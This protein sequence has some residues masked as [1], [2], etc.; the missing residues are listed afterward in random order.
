MLRKFYNGCWYLAGTCILLAAVSVSIARLLLPGIDE[1][2]L[3][4]QQLINQHSGYPVTIESVRAEWQ[5]W[6]PTLYLDNLVLHEPDGERPLASFDTASIT[7]AFFTSLYKRELIPESLIV[8]GAKLRLVRKKDGSVSFTDQRYGPQSTGQDLGNQLTRWLLSQPLISL[9]NTSLSWRDETTAQA[10]VNLYQASLNLRT[11]QD[12]IQID[13]NARLPERYG[14]SIRFALDATGDLTSGN[15]SGEVYL[16]G[17]NIQPSAWPQYSRWQDFRVRA[18]R[19]DLRLWSHWHNARLERIDALVDSNDTLIRHRDRSNLIRS[20]QAELNL[21][22]SDD[23]DWSLAARLQELSTWHGDWPVTMIQV[24][25]RRQ[26][27]SGRIMV[28]SAYMSHMEL[29][30]IYE[31]GQLNRFLP[32]Q[33]AERV[34]GSN[35]GGHLKALHYRRDSTTSDWLL[36]G[37]AR[38]VSLQG[39]QDRARL[40]GLNADFVL[41]GERGRLAVESQALALHEPDFFAAPIEA[42]QVSGQID[43][44]RNMDGLVRLQTDNLTVDS[45]PHVMKL[46]GHIDLRESGGPHADIAASL[47]GGDLTRLKRFI[48][49]TTREKLKHWLHHGLLGGELTNAALVLRG[50]LD[51]F[52]FSDQEGQFKLQAQLDNVNIEY[53]EQWPPVYQLAGDVRIDQ[54][55]LTVQIPTAELYDAQI[56][57]ITATIDDLYVEDHILNLKGKAS[58]PTLAALKFMRNSP[59][60]EDPLIQRLLALELNGDLQLTLDMAIALYPG[61][62]RI[63]GEV[64]LLDNSIHSPRLDLELKNTNGYIEFA[65][66]QVNSRD[67]TA[68]YHG[69][70]VDV[71][72][73]KQSDDS[74]PL[75]LSLQ[76]RFDAATLSQILR[77][78]LADPSLSQLLDERLHG[79]STWTLGILSRPATGQGDTL[80]I[81]SDLAGTAVN[82]PGPVGKQA[83]ERRDLTI[84]I[85]LPEEQPAEI[86]AEYADQ[87]ALHYADGG[88]N[89]HFGAEPV[90]PARAGAIIIGGQLASLD[91]DDW[92]AVI[93]AIAG[94]DGLLPGIAM[95]DRKLALDVATKRLHILNQS[96]TDTSL[97]IEQTASGWQL[98]LEGEDIDGRIN[99]PDNPDTEPVTASF[100]RLVIQPPAEKT[101]NAQ[102]P[103]PATETQLDPRRLPALNLEIDDFVYDQSA[104]GRFTL[105]AE[106]AAG[107]LDIRQFRFARDELEMQGS[108]SWTAVS[109]EIFSQ[110]TINIQAERFSDLLKTF[111]HDGTDVERGK[112]AIEI[113]AMWPGNPMNFSLATMDGSLALDIK[114]GQFLDLNPGT[115]GRLFGLLSLQALPRRLSLDFNDLF[116]KGFAFDFIRGGFTIEDG[117]AYTNDLTM[118]GPAALITVNGRVGLAARDY[119]Q[120]VT[121]IPQVS[122]SLP[123]AGALFGP[124]GIGV[125]AVIFLTGKV[126]DE[127][128]RQIDRLLGY[129]YDVSGSWENP[130]VE[131]IKKERT[132]ATN[133]LSN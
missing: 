99:L 77:E 27:E 122:D 69:Q 25:G 97:N 105:Q 18:G 13:G 68:L 34:K 59:L 83:S 102:P 109:D 9:R 47:S 39:D 94:P 117:N 66:Q 43:W 95:K 57:D 115:T 16:E 8:F 127:I 49:L 23:G 52:P 30:D 113:E 58:G 62:D 108:G 61:P 123:V 81:H 21:I 111:N 107:G 65:N 71:L 53:H 64:R 116:Q 70:P 82:L 100:S 92:F 98:R 118:K 22:R 91:M 31:L 106:K 119:D 28:N 3:D 26:H 79:E 110:F 101:V 89:L 132:R 11:W 88:M 2:R 56:R 133:P 72:I 45:R 46:R 17:D 128:P 19:T 87:L 48:P 90:G 84:E 24:N 15:W 51:R 75:E 126:F 7:F 80:R 93:N 121:V 29:R 36:S 130:V 20:L 67:L 86:T 5:G 55:K 76:G 124:V 103:A 120:V 32:D 60:A 74:Q 131:P 96:F 125:G 37:Q 112:T 73:N 54:R 85:R 42:L 1:Y 14:D 41:S 78:E 63:N 38:N 12:R 114:D 44:F 33:L 104:L 129:Q 50:E 35:A 40:N 4:I 6:N 10:A